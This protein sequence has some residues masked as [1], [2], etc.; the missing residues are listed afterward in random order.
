VKVSSA[1][2]AAFTLKPGATPQDHGNP[3]IS[4]LKALF[5]CGVSSIHE[6]RDEAFG[7]NFPRA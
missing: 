4:A 2:G 1:K 3:K 5:T 6:Y 7:V